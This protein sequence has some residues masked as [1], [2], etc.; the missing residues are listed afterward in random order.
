MLQLCIPERRLDYRMHLTI[1]SGNRRSL[2]ANQEGGGRLGARRRRHENHPAV[3]HVASA[4]AAEDLR[5]AP[6]Q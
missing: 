6:A 4:A 5:A 2:Q 1:F 3:L